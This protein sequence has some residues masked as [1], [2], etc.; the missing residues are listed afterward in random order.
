M[1]NYVS[2]ILLAPLCLTACSDPK[3]PLDGLTAAPTDG[4]SSD[5]SDGSATT[6]N[7]AATN[8]MSGTSD[9][10]GATTDDEEPP[11]PTST[12]ATTTGAD[13]SA[14]PTSDPSAGPT[15]DPSS[16]SDTT[17]DPADPYEQARQLCV[18]T[19]NMYR[20]TLGL[21]AY[22]RWTDAESCSDAE[23]AADGQ[24]GTPHGAFGMCGESAQ[25]ECPGWPSP[26][27]QSLPGCLEQMWA[28]GPGEDFQMHGH[29]INMS[30]E[31]YSMVACGFADAGGG[32]M[33][34]V[35]NFK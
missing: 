31:Q 21:P 18:D 13:P 3:D 32:S 26:A 33:W 8:S 28:E 27:E 6:G 17:G 34:M 16:A 11:N 4:S 10:P 2:L 5:G 29:Y 15:S 7:D 24:S 35:Q 22:Q 19:I 30:S 23:A 9:G 12:S 14:G 25:N 20:A 1:R